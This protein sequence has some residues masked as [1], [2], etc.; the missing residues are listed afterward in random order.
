MYRHTTSAEQTKKH[1][2]YMYV[3]IYIYI[4]CQHLV[5]IMYMV[6]Q[7]MRAAQSYPRHAYAYRYDIYTD[8]YIYI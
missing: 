6:V 2:M 5:Y 7:Q 1:Y 8:I 3:C 4:I